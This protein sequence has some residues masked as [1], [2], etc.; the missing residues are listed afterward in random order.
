MFVWCFVVI[1]YDPDMMRQGQDKVDGQHNE[2]CTEFAVQQFSQSCLKNGDKI[3]ELTQPLG[4]H[5]R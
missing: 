4:F 1:N 5:R 2:R 3:N